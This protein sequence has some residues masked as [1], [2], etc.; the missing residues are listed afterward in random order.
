MEL[1]TIASLLGCEVLC[2][3]AELERRVT[4]CYAADLMSD[5]LRFSTARALLITGLT[6]VQAIHT[7]DVADCRGILFVNDKRPAQGTVELAR[8][9]GIPLL[10]TRRTMFEACGLLFASGLKPTGPS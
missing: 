10:A 6:S 3:D 1:R 5:V 8:T 7:A 4:A 2:G 9:R